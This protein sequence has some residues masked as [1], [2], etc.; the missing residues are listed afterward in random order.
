MSLSIYLKQKS[1]I[2]LVFNLF[3]KVLSHV[4]LRRLRIQ[5]I[6]NKLRNFLIYTS[7]PGSHIFGDKQILIQVYA[8]N[9]KLIYINQIG[10]VIQNKILF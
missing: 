4:I 6:P 9:I 7:I 1:T 10:T 2:I 3:Q 5:L 8:F